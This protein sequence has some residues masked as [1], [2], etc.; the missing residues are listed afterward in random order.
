MLRITPEI[1]ISEDC[2]ELDFIRSSGPGGQNVNKVSTAVQLRFNAA[3]CTSLPGDVKNRLAK[4]AGGKMTDDGVLIIDARNCRTQRRNREDA[5]DRLI[6]LIRMAAVRPKRRRKTK[7]T[8]ASKK[9]RLDTKRRRGDIKR[10]RRNTGGE[11]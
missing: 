4:L 8:L 5:F 11:A 10:L 6:E 3:A 2:I 7:P 9:R 1:S